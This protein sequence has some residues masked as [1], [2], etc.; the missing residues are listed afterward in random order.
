MLICGR[1][2]ITPKF[3]NALD[4]RFYLLQKK[5]TLDDENRISSMWWC[6]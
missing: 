1:I 2:M 5:T 3:S 6:P 4:I